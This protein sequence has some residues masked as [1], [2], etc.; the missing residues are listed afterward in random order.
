MVVFVVGDIV[1]NEGSEAKLKE[2]LQKLLEP[3]RA[4]DGCIQYDLH[5]DLTDSGHFIFYEQWETK[6]HLQAHFQSPHAM[7]LGEKAG[8]LVKSLK[9]SQ[10][11]KL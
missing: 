6:E 7:A 4:E 3:T 1:A 5:E 10:L 8:D 9:V 11:K 2:E